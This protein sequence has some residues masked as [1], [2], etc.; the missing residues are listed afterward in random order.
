MHLWGASERRLIAKH[1]MY[2]ILERLRWP[3]KPVDVIEREYAQATEGRPWL[4]DIPAQWTYR[5]V[6][7]EWWA[8]YDRSL[9]DLDAVPWQEAWCD[10][11]VAKHGREMFAGLKI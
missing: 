1:R 5:S 6:P 10:E 9:I 7:A 11:M 4:N 8:V 2:R 3:D